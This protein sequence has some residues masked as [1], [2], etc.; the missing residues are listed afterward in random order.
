MKRFLIS[1][2]R[3][4]NG[5]IPL[6]K[7]ISRG[8]IIG[9][10]FSKQSGCFIDPTFPFL[11]EIGDNVTFSRNVTVLSHDSSTKREL[12]YSKIGNVHIGNN[13]FIGANATILPNVKIGNNVIIGAGSVVNRDIP[14][15][16][17]VY[18]NP[19]QI[20]CTSDNYIRKQKEKMTAN[21]T[22][23]ETVYTNNNTTEL[24]NTI[25]EK[26]E[27]GICFIK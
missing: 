12:G 10:N 2:K 19:A 23:D 4:I 25:K 22:F 13:C 16:M 5:E 20:L 11:I 6:K 26:C 7:L 17:V 8:L 1:I 27:N 14:D 24:K 21:N 9:R 3:L 15:N 18:G